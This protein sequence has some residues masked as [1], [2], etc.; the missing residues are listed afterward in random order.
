MS[1]PRKVPALVIAACAAVLAAALVAGCGGGSGGGGGEPAGLAPKDAPVYLAVD[2]APEAKTSEELDT[3]T[4]SVMG[5]ENVGEFIAEQLEKAALG[6]GEKFNFEEEV[7]PWLG[8]KAGMYLSGYDGDEFDDYGLALETT[9]AGEAEEFIEKRVESKEDEEPEEG[10]YEGD[11]YW[12]EPEDESVL[13]MIGDYVVFGQGKEDFEAMVEAFEGEGL[14]ESPRYKKAM[15]AAGEDG[16]G[17]VYVDIGGLIEEGQGKIPAETE[18]FFSLVGIEPK[19]ATAVAT[20]VPHSEA[21]EVDT[22]SNLGTATGSGGDATKLLESLPA[23]AVVGFASPEFGKSV[24]EGIDRLSEEGIPGQLEP[25]ELKGAL[26]TV[27]INLDSIFG[28]IGN[29][30]GFVEGSALG[31]LGGAVV[32]ETDDASEAKST[33]TQVGLLLQAAGTEGVTTIS[34]NLSGFSVHSAEL[35]PKP[36]IVGSAGEKIVIAYGPKAAARA[37]RTDGKTLGSTADFETAKGTLGSTP[38]TAF[39]DGGP[40][41]KLVEALLSPQEEAEIAEAR[42]YLQKIA[43]VAVGAEAEGSTTTAKVIVGLQK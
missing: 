28:S 27:G 18:S 36:L 39:V 9:S 32:I 24:G 3:L 8:E 6:E 15:E 14:N 2:L 33:I 23:T 19:K 35:G 20:V 21:I 1:V 37:L 22:S 16:I 17:S 31:S 29:A 40:A 26:E 12:I 13:G 10:E 41:L 7:E 38:M 34:G 30:G 42:P 11:K 4:G 5:I 25:G 43:Y